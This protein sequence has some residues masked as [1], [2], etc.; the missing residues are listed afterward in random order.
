M[1]I[2]TRCE[3]VALDDCIADA[4]TV[5]K[6]PVAMKAIAVTNK[7][8][9]GNSRGEDNN[10]FIKTNLT[11]EQRCEVIADDEQSESTRCASNVRPARKPIHNW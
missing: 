4:G 3:D 7:R 6:T 2:N 9:R 5:S 1:P 8:R 10:N 11:T